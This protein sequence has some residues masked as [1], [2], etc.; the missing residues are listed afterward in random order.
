[1]AFVHP[2]LVHA[3]A[4]A[5][6]CAAREGRRRIDRY[7]ADALAARAKVPCERGGQSTLP[8]AGR[9]GDADAVR[10]SDA[11]VERAQELA[12]ARA[13]V[14]Y[15][16]D[17]ARERGALSSLEAREKL[18]DCGRRTGNRRVRGVLVVHG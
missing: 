15:D 17:R 4:I 13:L 14:F 12:K 7:D 9:P 10:M 5:E 2:D 8:C 16:R 11:R 18:R 3:D 1:H 6:E